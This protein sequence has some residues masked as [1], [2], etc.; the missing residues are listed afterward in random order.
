MLVP[1]GTS[2]ALAAAFNTPIAAVLFSLEEIIADMNAPL[3]GS[4]VVASVSA[5]IV[6]RSILG[7]EPLFRVPAYQL[8]HPGELVAY[9]ALGLIGGIV[10]V[11][12]C[13]LLLSARA[14]ARRLPASSRIWHPAGGG[15]VIGMLLIGLPAATGVGYEYVD[16][17]L[18]GGLVAQTMLLLLVAKMGATALSY[19]SGNAGGIFG[20]T[21]YFGAM[22]G[23]IVGTLTQ[24][25][26]PFAV[27]EPG[28]YALVGMG[29]LF[30][31]IIR[32]P[33]TSV[34]VMFEIT[35]DYQII[36]PLMVAN[37]LSLFISRRYQPE[38]VYHALLR[39][40]GVHLP[41]AMPQ[42][43]AERRAAHVMNPPGPWLPPEMTIGEAIAH[44]GAGDAAAI[45][46]RPEHA[47]AIVT[48]ERLA[49]ARE[50]GE[51]DRPLSILRDEDWPHVHPD[52]SLDV[53][54]DRLTASG[55]LLPVV[56]RTNVRQV[57]GIITR[58]AVVQRLFRDGAGGP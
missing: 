8:V 56:A 5:V 12:F 37:M 18:N 7:N 21:L 13:K 57:I 29:A 25:I 51:G 47:I 16:Q 46:G 31:G 34:F 52:H 58:E 43:R 49:R 9:V 45:V 2:A 42:I 20:P 40:D 27:G 48:R 4:T 32:A 35:Q 24:Q 50:A 22:T 41:A 33:M 17:A 1:V 23:G 55:G 36:V 30:A 26:A 6:A 54:V 11:L 14:A 44:L 15:L 39:Q 19:A 53:V 38:P 3:L 10:S 28:A